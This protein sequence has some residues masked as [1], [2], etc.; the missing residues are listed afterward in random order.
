MKK[1]F[2]EMA[3]IIDRSGSMSGLE[4][5]TI[6]G[7]NSILRQQQVTDGRPIRSVGSVN[8]TQGETAPQSVTDALR[9]LREV[10]KAMKESADEMADDFAGLVNMAKTNGGKIP[11]VNEIL[12]EVLS[13]KDE[14]GNVNDLRCI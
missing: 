4:D 2:T 13:E 11:D 5:D 3:F 1:G 12:R 8:K 7:F 6:G 14:R 10:V 9:N